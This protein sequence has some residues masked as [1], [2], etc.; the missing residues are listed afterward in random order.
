LSM[1]R[2]EAA[3]GADAAVGEGATASAAD[4]RE[5]AI[6]RTVTY[7]ALFQFPLALPQLHRRLMGVS[8]DLASL[9][10][11]LDRPFLRARLAVTEG[12]VHPRG[13]ED[14]LGLRRER[15]ERTA[16]L[17]GRHRRLL[18]ALG[19]VPFVRLVALSG[20]CAHGN[21]TDDDVDVFLMVRRGRAW[22][23]TAAIM[24][25][26]KLLGVRRTLCVNYVL[27][28]AAACLPEHD[29]VTASEIVGMQPL[30]GREAYR[31]FVAANDWVRGYFPNFYAAHVEESAPVPRAS[32]PRW[33]EA[34]LDLGPAPLLEA[35]S[36]RVLGAWLRRTGDTP[37]V[38]LSNRRLKLHIRDHRP[39]LTEAFA[40]ALREAGDEP[41]ELWA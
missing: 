1:D 25:V 28:E 16:H 22:G 12:L 31:E 20:A 41:T 38:V 15:G 36:R 26:S 5:R 13:R 4:P 37:G 24:L 23:V 17:L 40:A 30:A 6:L 10:R 29:L 3:R 7:A 18:E 34:L 9:R 21:A 19:R 39:G 8:L 35:L 2:F 14:W 27:D 32:A 11:L 33:M